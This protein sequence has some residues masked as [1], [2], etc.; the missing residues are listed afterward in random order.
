MTEPLNRLPSNPALPSD[1]DRINTDNTSTSN[2]PIS[3]FRRNEARPVLLD[4]GT[5]FCRK[6]FDFIFT[7]LDRH[8]SIYHQTSLATYDASEKRKKRH[9]RSRAPGEAGDTTSKPMTNDSCE[10]G[11]HAFASLSIENNCIGIV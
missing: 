8:K 10:I 2:I 6:N 11:K 9:H 1:Q 3:D 4:D 5:V 7:L